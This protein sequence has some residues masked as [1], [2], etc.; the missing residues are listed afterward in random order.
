[1]N[2]SSCYNGFMEGW[3]MKEQTKKKWHERT[4]MEKVLSL[5]RLAVSLII[6]C[7][8]IMKYL[9]YWPN[10]LNLAIPLFTVYYLLEA[11]YY[12]K[13]DRDVAAFSFIIAI[14]I[15]GISCAVFFL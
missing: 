13:K 7:T 8:A 15:G 1:M 2:P 10:G 3:I 6:L 11:I 14:I 12:W 5:S 9:N 4:R